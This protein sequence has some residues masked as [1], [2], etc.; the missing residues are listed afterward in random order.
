ML[1]DATRVR[2][3]IRALEATVKP[4]A[5]V[6]D[7]GAGTAFFSI[8]ACRLGARRVYAID[9]NPVLEVG[10]ELASENGCDTRIE[11]LEQDA[12]Q[13]QLPERADVVLSDLRGGVPLSTGNLAAVA[14]ARSNFL[15]PDGILIPQQDKMRVGV[16]GCAARYDEAVGLPAIDDI[17]LGAMRRRLV[18]DVRKDRTRR[19]RPGDLLTEGTTWAVV[20][21]RVQHPPTFHG[22]ATWAIERRGV[23]HGLLVWFDTTLIGSEGFSTGPGSPSGTVYPQLFLPWTEPVALEQRDQVTVDLWAQVDGAPWGWNTSVADSNGRPRIQHKQSSFL[24]DL[25]RPVVPPEG[26]RP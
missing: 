12:L 7:L 19:V 10:R 9:T 6:V 8:V 11:F 3:Y 17:T 4:G 14:H 23:G 1:A 15:A 2:A 25:A 26:H 20:D 18:N 16:V 13:T 5:V 22:R 24:A 21:Y